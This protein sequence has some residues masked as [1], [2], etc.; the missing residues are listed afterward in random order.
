[1]ALIIDGS[2]VPAA[3]A[4]RSTS[5][6]GIRQAG[7]QV[8]H[9]ACRSYDL[10]REAAAARSVARTLLRRMRDLAG[11]QA[12]SKGM[13]LA[14]P[15]LGIDRAAAVFQPPGWVPVTL[16]NPRI[17]ASSE[18]TDEQYEGCLSM[19]DVR[20]LVPRSLW[21]EVAYEDFNGRPRAIRLER[22]AARLAAHEIDHL[23]GVLYTERMST[24]RQ[25]I[26]VSAYRGTGVPWVYDDPIF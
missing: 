9:N 23:Q 1:V 14:A 22:G 24:T 2:N 4:A 5:D 6:L 3:E 11:L 25:P 20:G 17:V 16:L 12:F 8:L 15:Q 21:I 19:F 7:D 26:P 18:R 13:G 10:P